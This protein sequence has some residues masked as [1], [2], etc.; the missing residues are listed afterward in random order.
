MENLGCSA[1]SDDDWREGNNAE[2]VVMAKIFLQLTM[3][4]RRLLPGLLS[5]LPR[6]PASI[7]E[8]FNVSVDDMSGSPVTAVFLAII[9]IPSAV[10]QEEP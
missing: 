5:F 8:Q 2:G 3:F 7:G 9:L 10:A 6:F 1:G 4:C